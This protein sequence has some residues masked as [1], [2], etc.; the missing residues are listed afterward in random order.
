[1]IIKSIKLKN[2]RN[3]S[4]EFFKLS[5]E[6]NVLYGDNAQGKTNILESIFLCSLGKSFRT[7]KEKEL[8]K[9]GEKRASIEI[10][11]EKSDRSGQIKLDISDK[12]NYFVNGIKI[13]KLSEILGNIYIVMFNPNDI[14][15]LKD[16]P[17]VRRRFLDIMISQL[18]IKYVYYLNDYKKILEQRNAYL[19]QVKLFNKPEE[20]LEIWDEKLAE[21]R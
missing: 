16:G 5:T 10:E 20:M 13:K 12:K 14:D 7:K 8:I 19:K 9:I 2:F 21:L 11:F 6:K 17:S 18:R 4:E 1:M 15:I 3:Y